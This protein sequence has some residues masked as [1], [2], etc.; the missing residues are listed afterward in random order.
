MPS[1]PRSR[2]LRRASYGALTGALVATGWWVGWWAPERPWRDAVGWGEI[3]VADRPA[4][5]PLWSA[6][7]T[8]VPPPELRWLGHSGFLLRWQGATFLLDPNTSEWCAIARRRLRPAPDLGSIGPVDAA[9]INHAHLDHLDLPT[10][11]SVGGLGAIVLPAGAERYLSGSIEGAVVPV[12]AGDSVRFGSVE[13]IAVEAAHNGSRRHPLRSR[14][15][16][17]GYVLRVDRETIYFAGDTGLANDFAAIGRRFRP[18]VAIL[19]IGAWAP[20][21]PMR[22][23][24][25]S[26]DDAVEAAMRLGAGVVV[27]CHFGTFTLALDR[28]DRALPRFAAAARA[29][30]VQWTLAP[31]DGER[32]IGGG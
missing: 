25:L 18:R 19:P 16:A 24:H 15:R 5:G 27:P 10:L 29:R 11:R 32:S 22:H 3:A 8:Q 1:R 30:G 7:S 31:L 14:L 21:F 12:R 6:A 20:R 13:V 23:Y 28:P 2:R 26:P 4:T 9:L 17:L